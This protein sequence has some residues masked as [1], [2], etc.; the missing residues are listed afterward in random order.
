MSWSSGPPAPGRYVPA[1]VYG[2]GA[3]PPGGPL[4][5]WLL[6]GG[7]LLLAGLAL[8]V[9]VLLGSRQ[10]GGAVAGGPSTSSSGTAPSPSPPGGGHEDSA[11][12][13]R[14]WVGAMRTGDHRTAFDLSCV[15]LREAVTAGTPSGDPAE[16]LGAYFRDRVLDGDTF[17]AA[18]LE[19]VDFDDVTRTDVITFTLT[20][21]DGGR[22]PLDVFVRSDGTVC[23]FL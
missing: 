3:D 23:D 19:R 13:A 2:D 8:L 14:A 11:E 9:A 17:T 6:L 22:V 12:V 18:R 21:E 20:V 16:Q 7:A 15:Q 10:D 5:R 1:E 4:L